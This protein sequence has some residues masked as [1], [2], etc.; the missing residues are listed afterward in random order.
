MMPCSN[1]C[2]VLRK[3]LKELNFNVRFFYHK[4]L[5]IKK[6]R[7]QSLAPEAYFCFT[8]LQLDEAEISGSLL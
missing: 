3:L 4:V 1:L 2:E 7:F 8:L 6:I 5:T